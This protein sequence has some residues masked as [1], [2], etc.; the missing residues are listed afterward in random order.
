MQLLQF[1]ALATAVSPL[2]SAH[3]GHHEEDASPELKSYKSHVR[4][5][6]ESCSF[7]WEQSGQKARAI[8]RRQATIDMH[9]RRLSKKDTSKVLNTSHY[10]S[11][12]D[13]NSPFE[14]IWSADSIPL[15]PEGESGPYWVV[16]ERLRSN[17]LESQPGVPVI[18]EEQYIDIE[19]CEPITDMFAEIWG[20]NATG[21]YSGLVADGNG[22]TADTANHDTT[23]LRGIQRTDEDGVVTFLTLFPGHYDGRTTHHHVVAHLN[24]T[25][26]PNNTL[27]GGYTPHIG[28]FFYDQDLI[29][30]VESTYPYNTNKIPQTHNSVDRVFSQETEDSTSDPVLHYAYLGD[31]IEDG[32]FAWVQVAIN[33]TAQHYPYY[34]NVL[35][36]DGGKNVTG[37]DCGDYTVI[38]G[39]LCDTGSSS[40]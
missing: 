16:G 15:N 13:L 22:N 23:F 32:I 25:L 34:T 26:L 31:K 20:C 19:T 33:T 40:K 30:K 24:T 17:I 12:I 1:L 38:D 7:H 18:I 27:A 9:R 10:E 8:A 5:S 3:P 37:T 11:N 4:R 2:V 39:G 36:D 14:E 29:E 21:V 6:A 28:Q 35:T